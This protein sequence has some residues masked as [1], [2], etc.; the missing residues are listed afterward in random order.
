MVNDE[1]ESLE[2]KLWSSV[3]FSSNRIN[4]YTNGYQ[5]EVMLSG[6]NFV[7]GTTMGFRSKFLQL[8]LPILSKS[9]GC[10]H[11]TW[12]CLFLS[13]VGAYGIPVSQSL[14][15][16]RQH[17]GQLSGA[18]KAISSSEFVKSVTSNKCAEKVI[19]ADA[20][21]CIYDRLLYEEQIGEYVLYEV[22]KLS[23][24]IDH[25]R[26]RALSET[27]RGIQKWKIVIREA[28]SGRY[29]LFSGGWRSI[30]RDLI[31]SGD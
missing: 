15:Q 19:L 24:K 5:L 7:Y 30:L 21:Q 26:A 22:D 28:M 9:F 2:L 6:G 12:I 20:Y 14:I 1:R 27:A 3:G 29:D 4:R 13:S 31:V 8:L 16:Y 23:G 25:L 11:D 10:A 18:G 17:E